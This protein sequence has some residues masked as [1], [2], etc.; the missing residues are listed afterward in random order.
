MHYDPALGRFNCI[1]KFA[2]IVYRTSPYVFSN[3]NPVVFVDP[4][5]LKATYNWNTGKYMDGGSEVSFDDTMASN[6]VEFYS[7]NSSQAAY[8]YKQIANSFQS[9]GGG[10]GSDGG[11]S[12]GWNPFKSFFRWIFGNK[13]T[14]SVEATPFLSDEEL[15]AALAGEPLD[16]FL[17][18]KY[19]L[20]RDERNCKS[21]FLYRR[22]FKVR[23]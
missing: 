21:R 15:K 2:E 19:N 12:G 16:N 14:K 8:I 11:R 3:N 10:S 7:V 6:G 23:W 17:D 13:S 5:G 18:G 20:F 4:S 9:G 1:D 22:W